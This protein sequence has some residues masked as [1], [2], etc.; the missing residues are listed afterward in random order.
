MSGSE[1]E[2]SECLLACC[3][4]VGL[5]DYFRTVLLVRLFGDGLE[6]DDKITT[7]V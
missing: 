7:G 1:G 2:G 3:P 4:A 5:S 6:E